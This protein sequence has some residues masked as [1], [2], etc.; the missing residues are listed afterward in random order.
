MQCLARFIVALSIAASTSPAHA[1]TVR[2]GSGTGC[3]T[4]SIQAAVDAADPLLGTVDVLIARNATYT[5]QQIVVDGRDVRLIGGYTDCLDTEPDSTRTVLSGVGGAS[6]SVVSLRGTTS[7][8]ELVNLEITGGDEVM[9]SS[10]FGGGLD[11]AGV[12]PR[13]FLQ[14]VWLH[15][16]GA[17]YGGGIS[18]RNADA[19]NPERVALEFRA[20]N[21]VSA[22]RAAI[23]GGGIHCDG[24]TVSM[25]GTNSGILANVAGNTLNTG[26][27]GGMRIVDCVVA[28][29]SART[30]GSVSTNSATG[31]G[32]G[33]SI[34]G[35]RSRLDLYNLRA[36]RPVRILGNT[37]D[38][39][40]GGIAIGSGA[41]VYGW[42]VKIDGNTARNGGGGVWLFDN[43]QGSSD[44]ATLRL[45]PVT[46]GAPSGAVNC[47]LALDCNRI[48]DNRSVTAGGT[49]VPGAAI[50]AR[51]E[52][53]AAVRYALLGTRID[54]NFGESLIRHSAEGDF[55]IVLGDIIGALIDGNDASGFLL[56]APNNRTRLGI[57]ET[58][59]AGNTIGGTHVIRVY[60]H[61]PPGTSSVIGTEM[62][63]SLVAQPGK[64][65]YSLAGGE[66]SPGA[67]RFVIS[68]SLSNVPFTTENRIRAPVF[69]DAANRDYRLVAGSP[70]I[71]WAPPGGS[72]TRDHAMRNFD[73][74]QVADEF[75]P[76]DL[77]AYEKPSADGFNSAPSIDVAGN[78]TMT[79][80]GGPLPIRGYSLSDPDGDIDG[81]LELI[82]DQGTIFAL[83]FA[84]VTTVQPSVDRVS[85]LGPLSRIANDP[86][87]SQA[88]LDYYPPL[89]FHGTV[90]LSFE[91]D[92]LGHTGVGASLRDQETRTITILP[93]NDAPTLAIGDILRSAGSPA[94][95]SVDLLPISS[96][97]VGP[98]NEAGQELLG[99]SLFDT[100]DPNGVL[101]TPPTLSPAGVLA[102]ALTGAAGIAELDAFVVDDG[103]SANGGNDRSNLARF[104]IVVTG[105]GLFSNGFESVE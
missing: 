11:I 60:G 68:N 12:H 30:T 34:T 8:V 19:A 7:L 54:L 43:E 99:Y 58:T 18:I 38:G 29:A 17:G 89:H 100:F 55:D 72:F 27:G 80:D 33:I 97:S 14:N 49:R 2:V 51:A 31:S 23:G 32:G 48:G 56:H 64:E 4:S 10:G 76:Q 61:P 39:S 90:S 42:D 69:V 91:I 87:A 20:D 13:V 70:G 84:G 86:P 44:L 101:A 16:N 98:A 96:I 77:G 75:G 102:F 35:S 74:P 103:G 45:S 62:L 40:G 82:A 71:D 36:D 25:T 104:R 1:A 78:F 53:D 92:D 5:A 41:E 28:I 79:E 21:L 83:F 93:V 105:D 81:E 67:V 50:L 15:D 24:A 85:I 47:A 65:L 88:I 37:A 73:I 63:R 57:Y 95:Y 9:T 94:A 26:A 22:N 59:I 3:Q 6:Q 66:I 46:G 52:D